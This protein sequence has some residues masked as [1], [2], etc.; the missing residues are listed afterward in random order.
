MTSLKLFVYKISRYFQCSA[1]N[2]LQVQFVFSEQRGAGS[3]FI[4]IIYIYSSAANITTFIWKVPF[5]PEAEDEILYYIPQ[6]LF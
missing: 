2:K 5:T 4:Q 1:Q 6:S 3:L